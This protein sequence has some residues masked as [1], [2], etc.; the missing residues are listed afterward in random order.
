M[1]LVC[2][3]D[4]ICGSEMSHWSDTLKQLYAIADSLV[5]RDQAAS[6]RKRDRR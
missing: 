1:Y 3:R 4:G 6:P 5:E 2:D